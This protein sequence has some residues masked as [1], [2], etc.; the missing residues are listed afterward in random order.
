MKA[1]RP[2]LLLSLLIALPLLAQKAQQQ[3]TEAEK[4]IDEFRVQARALGIQKNGPG[5]HTAA[6]KDVQHWHGRLY[7]NFRNNALDAIPHEVRQGGEENS[8]LRRNQFGLN[9]SGPVPPALMRRK[10]YVSISYEGVRQIIDRPT[11]ATVPT[12][13]ERTGNFSATVDASGQ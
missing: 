5:T 6:P 3:P 1:V 8:L 9:L 11:L 4:A 13:L 10:T 12:L 7:E 2:Y